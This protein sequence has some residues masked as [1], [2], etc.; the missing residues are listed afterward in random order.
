MA[1]V[2]SPLAMALN[3]YYT[4][5][6]LVLTFQKVG[7]NN[8]IYISLGNAATL[9]R[10]TSA[11]P[12]VANKVNFLNIGAA[13]TS[14]F[15]AGWA[16]DTDIY[17]GLSGV[18]AISATSTV[19]VDGDP[20]R[21]LY[22][23]AP[24]FAVGT[25]GA[26]NSSGWT[27]ATNTLMTNAASDINSQNNI[28]LDNIVPPSTPRKYDAQI[29]V[30]PTSDSL[31]D[32]M[33]PITVFQGTNIQGTGFQAFEGGVQQAGSATSFGTFGGAGTV[34]FALDLYRI[35]GKDNVS[36]QV[37]GELR[38]GSYEGTVTI[39]ANGMVSFIAQGAAVS[40]FKSWAQSFPALDTPEKQL[41]SADPDNDGLTNLMEFVLNG[42][43]GISDSSSVT[44]TLNATGTDFVFAFNRRDDS[45]AG[46]TLSFEYSSDMVSWTPA[47]IGAAGAV[48]GS[49]TIV[50]TENST[51]PDAITVTIPKTVAPGGKLF[52]RLKVTQP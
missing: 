15:G 9:Y 4:T 32:N 34:E 26:A 6:D 2:S 24:R 20:A 38:V 11:G 3:S 31:I 50:V 1:L 30:S 5:G 29:I 43:P 21:T 45:E 19:L 13:L 35:V 49:A 39:G 36:G 8:T 18:K 17:A 41:P 42:N 37:A 27:V 47:T 16:S 22:V 51:D 7:S 28:F 40:P 25:V 33:Q 48:V 12:D 46:N 44:P 52:G 14:A 23:S 10:G